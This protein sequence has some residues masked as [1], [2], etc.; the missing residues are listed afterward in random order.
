MVVNKVMKSDT[1]LGSV[2]S[3]IEFQKL[4]GGEVAY[5][6]ELSSDRALELY[7]QL[8]GVPK[9]I[10]L[11]ALHGADGTPLA[12]TDTRQ[13]CVAQAMEGELEIASVH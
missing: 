9:G 12:L 2:M 5:I 8:K 7:P 4:G 6:T 11:F 13:A 3:A 1:D 10:N